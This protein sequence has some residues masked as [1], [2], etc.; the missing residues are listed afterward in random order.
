MG[1][2]YEPDRGVV[3]AAFDLPTALT[4]L[5]DDLTLAVQLSPTEAR[6]LAG[7]LVR[8]ADEAEGGQARA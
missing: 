6:Q 1:V 5:V 8:K 2:A 7:M 4:R 3:V